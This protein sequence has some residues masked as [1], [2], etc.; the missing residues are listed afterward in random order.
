M[1][2]FLLVL[3]LSTLLL[4]CAQPVEKPGESAKEKLFDLNTLLNPKKLVDD[5]GYEI[6]AGTPKRIVSLAPS[7]TEILFAISAG[8]RVVGVT[9]YCNYPPEVSEKRESGELATIGGYSTINIEKIL[10]LNPDLVIASYGNGLE[11]IEYLRKQG[12]NVIAFDPKNIT[13][14]MKDIILIGIATG[15]YDEAKNVVE[16][17]AQK[18]ESVWMKAKD[19]RKVKVAHIVW[20]DPIWVS[21]KNTFIDEVIEF[22]GGTNVFDFEGWKT[23]SVEDLIAKNPEVIIVNSG[24]GM[25]GGKNVVYE[26][27][28]QDERLK[29]VDAVKNGRIYVI[30]ADIIS[31]PSYRLADAIEIVYSFLHS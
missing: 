1:R 30:N 22:A 31:R 29:S 18:I 4:L 13:D 11:N 7:N 26:W 21:G 8:D 17:M 24:S 15:N 6:H 20:H 19:K 9:D 2:K 23:I 25:G 28:L 5:T 12:L 3:L 14:V 10:A 27:V 16:E